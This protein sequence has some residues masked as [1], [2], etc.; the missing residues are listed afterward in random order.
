MIK[1]NYSELFEFT[2]A[3][4]A[5]LKKEYEPMRGKTISFANSR[6]LNAMIDRKSVV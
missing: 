5:R 6:K 2:S 4:L 1:K 3:Q